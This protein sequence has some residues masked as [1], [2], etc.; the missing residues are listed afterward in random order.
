VPRRGSWPR[1]VARKSSIVPSG[2]LTRR[3]TFPSGAVVFPRAFVAASRL[4]AYAL[5]TREIA[6]PLVDS[7]LAVRSITPMGIRMS[8]ARC[9]R[10]GGVLADE[11][12]LFLDGAVTARGCQSLR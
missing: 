10:R 3:R 5:G 1:S 6:Q 12:P 4:S 11:R 9:V 8:G 7:D 2:Q